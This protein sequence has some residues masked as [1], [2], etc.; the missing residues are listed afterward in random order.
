MKIWYEKHD[1]HSTVPMNSLMA[2]AFADHMVNNGLHKEAIAKI[3][4]PEMFMRHTKR[5]PLDSYAVI[6][7]GDY[8]LHK[9]KRGTVM[10]TQ[11]QKC[12]SHDMKE[13]S[14]INSL[15]MTNIPFSIKRMRKMHLKNVRIDTFGQI[16]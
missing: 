12:S 10:I 16:E 14:Y 3:I 6:L 7:S 2:Q 8:R 15:V 5:F 9:L 11:K 4:T 13:R 1:S